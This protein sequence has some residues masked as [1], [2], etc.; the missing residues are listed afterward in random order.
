MPMATVLRLAGAVLLV[1]SGAVLVVLA[2]TPDGVYG[3]MMGHGDARRAVMSSLAIAVIQG[4]IVLVL[5]ATIRLPRLSV[6]ACWIGVAWAGLGACIWI[7]LFVSALVGSPASEE[8]REL[9]TVA[10][11][12]GLAFV[13]AVLALTTAAS[14]LGTDAPWIADDRRGSATQAAGVNLAAPDR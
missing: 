8:S 6:A 10:L 13:F 4:A 2:L 14:E 7:P 3:D 12:L 9:L 5:L 11:G 1:A